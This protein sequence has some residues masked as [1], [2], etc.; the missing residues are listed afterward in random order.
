MTIEKLKIIKLQDFE[1]YRRVRFY[2]W[3]MSLLTLFFSLPATTIIL[4]KP[5]S[6][7]LK[8]NFLNIVFDF[9]LIGLVFGF[10]FII[11]IRIANWLAVKKF[12]DSERKIT[13]LE[14]YR[15]AKKKRESEV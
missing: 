9:S 8:K 15:A 11:S 10:F 3:A 6:L 1:R 5:I 7:D 4:W 14:F 13:F 12:G 2:R